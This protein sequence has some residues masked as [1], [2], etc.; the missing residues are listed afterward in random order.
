MAGLFDGIPIENRFILEIILEKVDYQSS[1]LT[2][3][4]NMTKSFLIIK[5]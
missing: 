3:W 1:L 5:L 4:T 2:V